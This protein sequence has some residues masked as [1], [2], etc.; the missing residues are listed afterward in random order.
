MGEVRS[1][2]HLPDFP[3]ARIRAERLDIREFGP[4]DAGLV[5][6]VLQDGEWLPLSTA[7][8]ETSTGDDFGQFDRRA[9]S[10]IHPNAEL[11]AR[12]ATRL[13]RRW[14]DEADVLHA[15]PAGR[16]EGGGPTGWRGGRPAIRLAE[17]E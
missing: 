4:G 2:A 13:P 7:L 14:A 10:I 5:R 1:V 12:P 15:W 16:R 6:E 11:M 9:V 17:D 3:E 8:A